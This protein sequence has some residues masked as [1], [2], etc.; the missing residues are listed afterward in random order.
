MI[1][2]IDSRKLVVAFVACLGLAT[3]LIAA[4]PEVG[5]GN[6]GTTG[7]ASG[8]GFGSQNNPGV[9]LGSQASDASGN[10]GFNS[11]NNPGVLG[12]EFG[13]STA[14]AAGDN[15]AGSSDFGRTTAADAGSNGSDRPVRSSIFAGKNGETIVER[16]IEKTGKG[17]ETAGKHASEKSEVTKKFESS[18]LYAGIT[19]IPSA[20]PGAKDF[21]PTNNPG[22]DHMSQQ[23]LSSSEFGRT[24][25]EAART[26]AKTLPELAVSPKPTPRGHHYGWE[27]GEHNPHASLSPALT[28]TTT[29]EAVPAETPGVNP[30]P[31]AN[32]SAPPSG[33]F[34]PGISPIPS[35]PESRGINPVPSATV[36]VGGP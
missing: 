28:T 6:A 24:T 18:L 8:P 32:P 16:N 20:T 3:Y 9:L 23:G 5:R 19:P 4:P 26:D 14:G 27:K 21:G 31:S 1:K 36:S 17:E 30:V 22:L 35:A 25:A 29:A 13:R 2:P 15:G 12:S 7:A 33:T 10:P 11:E 34:N